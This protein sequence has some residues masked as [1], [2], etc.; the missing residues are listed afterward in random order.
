MSSSESNGSVR[1]VEDAARPSP[2]KKRKWRRG[3]ETTPSKRAKQFP[4]DMTVRGESMWCVYCDCPIQH[5]EKSTASKHIAG[6]QH[7]KNKARHST[8]VTRPG[9][10]APISTPPMAE[11]LPTVDLPK[12][13]LTC[14]FPSAYPPHTCSKALEATGFEGPTRWAE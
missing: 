13:S 7:K 12:G 11:S 9:F 8:L 5:M 1:L 14:P 3:K 10:S 6:A 2:D 4:E